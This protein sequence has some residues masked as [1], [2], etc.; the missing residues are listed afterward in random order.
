LG[1]RK[2]YDVD[3]LVVDLRNDDVALGGELRLN[4]KIF[5]NMPSK[6]FEFDMFRWSSS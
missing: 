4:F 2:I 1:S 3:E 6:D 5:F